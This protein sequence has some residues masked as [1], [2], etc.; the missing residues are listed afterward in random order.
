LHQETFAGSD[1]VAIT[2][3]VSQAEL[4]IRY[5]LP[6]P[7][8]RSQNLFVALGTHQEIGAAVLPF[9]QDREGST[10]F[11]PFKCDLLLLAE[12][13]QDGITCFLRR[14]ERWRWSEPEETEAF[15]VARENH[16]F[17]F[18]LPCPPLGEL[19]KIDFV[20]YAKD[21]AASN[22]WGWLWGCSDSSVRSGL[23]DKYI[24]HYHELRLVGPVIPS[25]V[26]GPRGESLDVQRGPSTSLRSAQDDGVA[27]YSAPIIT[28]HGRHRS[29][30][31]R[32]RLYQLFVRLFS[33]VKD[34]L[35]PNGTMAE[36]GVGK[37]NHITNEAI[38]SLREMGFSHIWLTGVLQQATGTDYSRIGRPAD[39]ADLLKGVA[40]SPYAIKDYFDLCPDY[41]EQ[42]ENRLVEFKALL[43]RIHQHGMKALIDF[44]PNHVAR[45]YDSAVK[46]EWNFGIKGN[47]GA[48]DDRTKFFDPQNNFFY[49]Q[50]GSEQ[51]PLRLPTREGA[52]IPAC[53][54]LFQGEFDHCKVTGNNVA[55]WAPNLVDWYETVKLNY[56]FDF[57][58]PYKLTREYPS[59]LAPD[60]PLPDTWK[61]MD[62]VIEHWQGVGVD[63]FRCD[64]AH[65][66]PPEFWNWLIYRARQRFAGVVFIAEAYDNDP[67]K[68]PGS[69]PFIARLNGERGNVM[70]DLLN[71][72]FNAVYD[73]PAYK[74]LKNVYDGQGWANDIDHS[75]GDS[76]IF[77]NSLRYAENHDEVR[78]AAASQWRGIGMAVGPP[79]AAILYGLSRGPAM[80]YNGQEVGEPGAEMEG[81]GGDDAR[82]S[83]FDYWAMPEFRKWVNGHRFDGAALSAEQKKIRTFY[84]QLI[85]LTGEP[86]FQDGEFF[87]LNPAN[88]DNP[89]FGRL[90]DEHASGHWLYAFLRYDRATEQRFLI[91][92][93]LHPTDPLHDVSVVLSPSAMEFLDLSESSAGRA[94]KFVDRLARTQEL[95]TIITVEEVRAAGFPLSE[96]APLTPLYLEFS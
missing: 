70:F 29:G 19:P 48:G 10:V 73:D 65:M 6:E 53:D 35:K 20:I 56:G 25:E 13:R 36:N 50:L 21:P 18:R 26:E 2:V 93:N 51:A 95:E 89:K 52:P 24:P 90:P 58:D 62:R 60:K 9:S 47:G 91:V 61:K 79:V 28:R 71:A 87:P 45:S 27:G 14:W 64:M 76:F 80:L 83:I 7:S 49:L 12:S 59:A 33:N 94:L 84:G 4:I 78:L 85:T 22:G 3:A 34:Y 82:T 57:T 1:N 88:H 5:R 63:G 92:A 77:D 37:F 39:D 30:E 81:F 68:V 38:A 54:R 23:G 15:R 40:G 41:A 96:I 8:E 69:D 55:S 32:I 31:S 11:L 67:T 46:P 43:E 86:A 72:G 75:L 74:A 42:P 16:E 17:V 44:V 66:V